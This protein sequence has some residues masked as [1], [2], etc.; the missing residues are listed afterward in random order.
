MSVK[1]LF[2]KS[3]LLL[4]VLIIPIFFILGILGA[5][6]AEV[7]KHQGLAGGAIVL[8]Y[9]IITALVAIF[10]A[11][12]FVYFVNQELIKKVNKI[13]ALILGLLALYILFNVLTKEKPAE[14]FQEPPRTP[15]KTAE[16]VTKSSM[17][18]FSDRNKESYSEN[19]KISLGFFK[20]NIFENR[21]LY[22]YGN[23]N[24]EKSK[25]E[26]S[27]TDSVVFTQIENGGYDITY[28]P[29]WLVPI[30]L[31]L[32]YDI[33]YFEVTS[34]SEDFAKVIVNQSNKNLSYVDRSKGKLI[35]WPDFLLS[36]NSV[37]FLDG[38]DNI[39]RIKPLE[40]ASEVSTNFEIM[41]PVQISNNWMQV[42]LIDADYNRVG[43]GWIKWK[44][45]NRLLIT[46][47]LLS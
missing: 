7:A 31:K 40:H 21:V 39:V 12:I 17:F 9:G 45:N 46:Y 14:K 42:F 34:V 2:N 10:L 28:A 15:T 13:F 18:S 6:F 25:M 35:Y 37:E 47:S 43:K 8:F 24:F 3:A 26:H 29:P 16:P 27:Q 1:K 44:M 33:L 32:D 11:G 19:D 20:P 22:F 30:H 23:P 5:K 36:V 41:K 4:Y 38:I